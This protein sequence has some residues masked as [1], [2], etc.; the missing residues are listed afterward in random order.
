MAG[1]R[2]ADP[3]ATLDGMPGFDFSGMF[4]LTVLLTMAVPVVITVI[5]IGTVVWAIRRATAPLQDPAL[6]ELRERLARGEIDP[7][8]YQARLDALRAD[9]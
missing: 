6:T 9:H 5:V 3:A 4:F 7:V 8:E 1:S 2:P